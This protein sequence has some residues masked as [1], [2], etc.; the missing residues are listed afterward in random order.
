MNTE[1]RLLS[2]KILLFLGIFVFSAFSFAQI[3][4]RGKVFSAT[5]KKPIHAVQVVAEDKEGV[6]IS[7]TKTNTQGEFTLSIGKEIEFYIAIHHFQYKKVRVFYSSS[8]IKNNSF[9]D[10]Y[11]ESEI[12][13]ID[14]VIIEN[15]KWIKENQDTVTIQ[16]KPFLVGNETVIEDLMKKL[17]GVNVDK[18]G[19]IRVGNTE[20]EKVMV[21]GDDFFEKNYT[22]L[23]QN[24]PV[25]TI[26]EVEI[27]KNFTHNKH[28]KSIIPSN[29][30]AINL[31]LK[32]EYR[33]I[34]FGDISV[35][36]A[37]F[38]ENR[39]AYKANVIQMGKKNKHFGLLNRMTTGNDA[40][41]EVKK[42]L[43]IPPSMK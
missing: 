27:I 4:I 24:M 2:T 39:E 25:Y 23:T 36:R 13:K 9:L 3:V 35:A 19:T 41:N 42:W 31:K 37:I 6:P 21:E 32:N 16:A 14:E 30:V 10:F 38:P 15:K 34:T 7:F 40:E 29:K 1:Q 28:L 26:K 12:K 20:I 22:I 11:L 17:P 43:N 5:D 8:S 18:N 33:H